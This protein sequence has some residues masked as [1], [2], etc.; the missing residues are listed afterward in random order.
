MKPKSLVMKLLVLGL[1][2]RHETVTVLK[3]QVTSFIYRFCSSWHRSWSSLLLHSAHGLH[4][5]HGFHRLHGSLL[6]HNS[7]GL[8]GR[9]S[10][11]CGLHGPA[12]SSLLLHNPHG[13]H[14][15]RSCLRCLHGLHSP[16]H[17]SLLLHDTHCL[18]CGHCF[19]CLHCLR[20]YEEKWSAEEKKIRSL[21]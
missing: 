7:H 18:H 6:L 12:H 14:S 20:H 17:G 21:A 3:W 1:R 16:A 10:C 15:R 5:S 13:L 2:S 8:H 4:G 19:H 11:L 9:G